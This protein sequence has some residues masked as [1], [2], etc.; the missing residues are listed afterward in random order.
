MREHHS[1]ALSTEVTDII[2][3]LSFRTGFRFVRFGYS[4]RDLE[5]ELVLHYLRH[6][7]QH[8]SKRAS[9]ATYAAS[10]CRHRLFNMLAAETAR[11]RGG[12]GAITTSLSDTPAG[13]EHDTEIE[14]GE[15]ISRD[16][17]EMKFGRISQATSE[18]LIL[19]LDV[20]RALAKLPPEL[21]QIAKLL[22]QGASVTVLSRV[23]GISRATS[24]RRI[25][26]LRNAFRNAGLHNYIF[27]S[28]EGS[29]SAN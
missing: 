24:H 11:K 26:C 13:Y 3:S 25:S 17:Y 12:C 20:D 5:Q 7:H 22:S 28:E 9:A 27:K 21:V 19:R 23:L 10:I 6:H 14:L 8:D 15:T 16:Y 2:R 1:P 4:R 18:L 29:W